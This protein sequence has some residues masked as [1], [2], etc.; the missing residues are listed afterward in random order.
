MGRDFEIHVLGVGGVIVQ[1]TLLRTHT[2]AERSTLEGAAPSSAH[3]EG[4][5]GRDRVHRAVSI[6][7]PSRALDEKRK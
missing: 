1:R 4:G 6:A 3:R 5:G 7:A 2:A